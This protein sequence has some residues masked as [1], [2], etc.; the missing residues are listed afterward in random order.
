MFKNLD[1]KLGVVWLFLYVAVVFL[2]QGFVQNRLDIFGQTSV[3]T[4][5]FLTA[6]TRGN[7]LAHLC[8]GLNKQ[9]SFSKVTLNL[10]GLQTSLIAILFLF[11]IV[12]G[13][14]SLV[15]I[16]PIFIIGFAMIVLVLFVFFIRKWFGNTLIESLLYSAVGAFV[17]YLVVGGAIYMV[18]TI[19][20]P[21]VA[22]TFL[23]SFL[24]AVFIR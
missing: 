18:A 21:V 2:C 5:V 12:H 16:K 7:L 1:V 22:L 9:L 3:A 19:S 23:A 17:V 20:M 10:W 6:A 13:V 14:F 4:L 11:T 15:V 24:G 8:D